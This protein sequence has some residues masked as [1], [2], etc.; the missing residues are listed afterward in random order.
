MNTPLPLVTDK[1]SK[2][3][4]G[5]KYIKRKEIKRKER[6]KEKGG[7]TERERIKKFRKERCLWG[8]EHLDKKERH[9]GE[10]KD[11][12]GKR[13]TSESGKPL[14]KNFIT[15]CKR[16]KEGAKGRERNREREN[17]NH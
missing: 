1:I 16:W 17:N 14:K 7:V 13:K 10:K 3:V 5:R 11:I 2:V 9:L 12:F 8:G 6:R 4:K 15:T